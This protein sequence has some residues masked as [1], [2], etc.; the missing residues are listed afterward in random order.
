MPPPILL[1]R[2]AAAYAPRSKP[3]VV[4]PT[5]TE[6]WVKETLKRIHCKKRPLNSAPQQQDC[7][8]TLLVGEHAIWSLAAF[9]IPSVPEA[10]MTKNENPLAEALAN[11]KMVHVTGYVVHIDMVAE[12]EVAFKLTQET[13]TTLIDYYRNIYLV[14]EIAKTCLW[15]EKDA[16]VMKLQEDFVQAIN[17]YVFRTGSRALEGMEEGGAGELLEGQSERAKTGI[18]ALFKP[19]LPPPPPPPQHQMVQMVGT[20]QYMMVPAHEGMQQQAWLAPSSST[21][22][23]SMIHSDPWQQN[24]YTAGSSPGPMSPE[25]S[26]WSPVGPHESHMP[27]PAS[28]H[29]QP[30]TPS[31]YCS[32]A[33]SNFTTLP[34]STAAML[35]PHCGV[36]VVPEYEQTAWTFNN[37]MMP[38][39]LIQ[40]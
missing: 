26:V 16:Q 15:P 25:S 39:Y 22:Q 8:E 17:S 11:C 10:R 2:S 40:T 36:T 18:I 28:S 13:I 32:P 20:A 14:D 33:A 21:V 30:F 6:P 35:I 4:L 38:Q 34:P 9:V 23:Q 12:H 27:S 7:L 31:Q 29:S 37:D 5:R 1:P 3:T 19:L 24:H